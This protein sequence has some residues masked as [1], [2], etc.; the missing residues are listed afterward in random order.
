MKKQIIKSRV[1]LKNDTFE[2]WDKAQNF[3][4]LKGEV[5]VYNSNS[6]NT[7]V[8]IKIGNGVYNP[9]TNQIEG[10]TVTELPFITDNLATNNERFCVF[11]IDKPIWSVEDALIDFVDVKYGCGYGPDTYT[12]TDT[13][14]IKQEIQIPKSG[15]MLICNANGYVYSV[16]SINKD[17]QMIMVQYLS[18]ATM[19]DQTFSAES[20]NAQ[21]GKAV[22]E[23]VA[24]IVNSAPETLDTLN[25]LSK[26]L[27]DDPNF[28]AT[29]ATELGNKVDKND[30]EQQYNPESENAQSGKAVAEAI[31]EKATEL[32]GA[33]SSL[34]ND[35]L[36][37][38]ELKTIFN[39]EN[40]SAIVTF[41]D[42][43]V[44]TNTITGTHHEVHGSANNI[45]GSDNKVFGF[46]N[47]IT[48]G[49]GN[50]IFGNEN[51]LENGVSLSA[52]TGFNNTIKAG[53]TKVGI[54]GQNIIVG[55]GNS[56]DNTG[57]N[58]FDGSGH[59]IGDGY[60]AG[61]TIAGRENTTKGFIK[62]LHMGGQNNTAISQNNYDFNATYINGYGNTVT[63]A[64]YAF[65]TGDRNILENGQSALVHGI[66]NNV[67]GAG[68]IALGE[69]VRIHGGYNH[70]IGKSSVVNGYYNNAIGAFLNIN[71]NE[72][73]RTVLGIY[74]DPNDMKDTV[75]V[76]GTGTETTYTGVKRENGFKVMADG[77]ARVAHTST[78]PS[79]VIRYDQMMYSCAAIQ[80]IKSTE[81]DFKIILNQNFSKLN[82]T[83][84]SIGVWDNNK[85][86]Y[87]Y[88]VNI[89][90]GYGLATLYKGNET[91]TYLNTG[92]GWTIY[93]YS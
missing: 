30:I 6:Q 88:M 8:K 66:G 48:N 90:N 2:N 7:P 14:N 92:L 64:K 13:N 56:E 38:S 63:D 83:S 33:Y 28:A 3:I 53:A 65:V 21:S 40:S 10:T 74:N 44:A 52:V 45:S 70:I 54:R 42:Y 20:K 46:Q 62:S 79:A 76:V 43:P 91:Q 61:N 86:K 59:T 58:F 15:D 4:P 5:I 87:N 18:G 68:N 17:S 75:L 41:D 69:G 47:S 37:K 50:E 31:S 26:A 67:W 57:I 82:K 24:S 23:A 81:T 27:G 49:L 12:Y 32:I 89:N 80:H 84:S 9:E 60:G 77:S 25:E 72:E 22:A 11:T 93:N 16:I 34:A 78:E 73:Y 19:V 29:V 85:G 51:T 1:V 39:I 36:K 35:A 55:V 71:E